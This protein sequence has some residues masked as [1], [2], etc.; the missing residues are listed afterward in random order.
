MSDPLVRQS[1]DL[2]EEAI[3]VDPHHGVDR[4]EVSGV[5]YDRNELGV[6]V[7]YRIVGDEVIYNMFRDLLADR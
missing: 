3:A 5:I 1:L 4:I 2:D 6:L 7:S